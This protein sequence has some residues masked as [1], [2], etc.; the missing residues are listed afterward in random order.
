MQSTTFAFLAVSVCVYISCTFTTVYGKCS[1]RWAIHACY[2]GNGKRSGP[3]EIDTDSKLKERQYILRQLLLSDKIPQNLASDSQFDSVP[4]LEDVDSLYPD[5]PA[6]FN[7]DQ[8]I[9]KVKTLL[10]ELLLRKRYRESMADE[11][12]YG[13][14]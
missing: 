10:G 14:K 5:V 13:R 1:G 2:G 6:S 4:V 12:D 7:R 11:F 8:D 3:P 9:E